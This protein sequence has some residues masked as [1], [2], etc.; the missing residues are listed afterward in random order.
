MP[1]SAAVQDPPLGFHL[2]R[3]PGEDWPLDPNSDEY[4]TA[5]ARIEAAAT[6]HKMS[7]RDVPNQMAVPADPKYMIC[8][9]PNKTSTPWACNCDPDNMQLPVCGNPYPLQQVHD[10]NGLPTGYGSRADH[11]GLQP[12]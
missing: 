8:C 12:W 6:V 9:D 11:A 3:D 5:R 2:E 10:N 4:A 7:V 1:L